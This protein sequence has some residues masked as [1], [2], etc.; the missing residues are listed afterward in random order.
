MVE[1]KNNQYVNCRSLYSSSGVM[2]MSLVCEIFSFYEVAEKH[3]FVKKHML[4]C[5]LVMD[6]SITDFHL[7]SACYSDSVANSY[8]LSYLEWNLKNGINRLEI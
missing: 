7:F 8:Q 2:F 1:K 3:L 6:L 5:D 4:L